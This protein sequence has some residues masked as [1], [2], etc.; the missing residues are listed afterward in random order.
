M[1]K[2]TETKKINLRFL[3]GFTALQMILIVVFLSCGITIAFLSASQSITNRFIVAQP[4]IGIAEPNVPNPDSVNW[5]IDNK[6]VR[7]SVTSEHASLYVKAAII[8]SAKDSAGQIFPFDFGKFSAPDAVTGE[9][10]IGDFTL[11]FNPDWQDDWFYKDGYFY[12][13]HILNSGEQTEVLLKGITLT[14]PTDTVKAKYQK[15][16]INVDVLASSIQAK[17]SAVT[18]WGVSLELDGVTLAP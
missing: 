8:I 2:A 4:D 11:H 17:G 18:E 9:L 7:I 5:G 13:K 14:N 6:N 3:A 16:T 1:R 12:Y 15:L 10:I